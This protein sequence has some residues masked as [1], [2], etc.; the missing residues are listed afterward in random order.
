MIMIGVTCENCGKDLLDSGDKCCH[1]GHPYND[2]VLNMVQGH[3]KAKEAMWAKAKTD[4]DFSKERMFADV[5]IL[6]EA[7]QKLAEIR[8]S[9]DEGGHLEPTPDTIERMFQN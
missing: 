5:K 9:L 8:G 1:C 6:A 4:G 3:Q 7:T 2:V